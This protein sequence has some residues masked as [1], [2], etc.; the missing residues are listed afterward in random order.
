ML[1][2]SGIVQHNLSFFCCF[3]DGSNKRAFWLGERINI[4]STFR[5]WYF[6]RRSPKKVTILLVPFHL[7]DTKYFG[8]RAEI[9]T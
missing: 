5:I 6:R 3:A 1:S 7:L 9:V 4:C 8:H 2:L